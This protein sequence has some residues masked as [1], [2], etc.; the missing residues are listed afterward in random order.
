ML[1]VTENI[2]QLF[3][4]NKDI[5]AHEGYK[6][7]Q[8]VVNVTS[9]SEPN[10]VWY[11]PNCKVLEPRDGP[12]KYEVYTYPSGTE[13]K[14]KIYDISLKDRGVYQLQAWS[15][16]DEQWAYFTLNVEGEDSLLFEIF[17][18]LIATILIVM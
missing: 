8:W 10:L 1:C 16:E 6:A 17:I 18:F 9:S 4:E 2:I 7:I 15:K 3:C 14:L 5:V 13:T 11:G 12:S